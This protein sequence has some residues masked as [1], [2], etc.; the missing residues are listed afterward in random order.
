MRIHVRLRSFKETRKIRK[1]EFRFVS[2]DLDDLDSIPEPLKQYEQEITPQMGMALV[3]AKDPM[4]CH[5]SF[6]DHFVAE[7]QKIMKAFGVNVEF[8]RA[9]DLYKQENMIN[10][11]R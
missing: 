2:D 9:S 7:T 8:L 6:A 5:N 10:S 4:K 11:Q 1:T 3:Y